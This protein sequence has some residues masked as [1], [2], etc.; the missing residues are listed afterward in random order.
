MIEPV[1]KVKKEIH[2]DLH[3]ASLSTIEIELMLV[4]ET[5][6]QTMDGQGVTC[7]LGKNQVN[8]PSVGLLFLTN[9]QDASL[10]QLR[11]FNVLDRALHVEDEDFWK[12]N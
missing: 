2:G 10:G 9:I 8:F 5:F 11:R 12:A 4:T 7:A 3:D 1:A 6:P